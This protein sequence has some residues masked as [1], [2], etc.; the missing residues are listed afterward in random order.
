VSV[1]V[2][3]SIEDRLV[4]RIDAEARARGLTRSRFLAL[5]AERELGLSR[6]PGAQP[7]VRSALASIDQ[8]FAAEKV[9]EEA[10]RVVREARDQR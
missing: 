8:L 9:H 7:T 4:R 10:S 2:L 3:V 5:L 6:G 1:K